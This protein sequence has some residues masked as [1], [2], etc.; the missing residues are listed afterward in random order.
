MSTLREW[1][2]TCAFICRD[3]PDVVNLHNMSMVAVIP[4]LWALRRIGFIKRLVWDQRELPD[5]LLDAGPVGR[6]TLKVLMLMCDQVASANAERRKFIGEHLGTKVR[7]RI[8]VIN[9]Y[10]DRAFAECPRMALPGPIVDWLRG[11][12]YLLAQSA[13]T[14]GRYFEEIAR[15]AI[16]L[17]RVPVVAVG[18]L[19]AALAM[20]LAALLEAPEAREWVWVQHEVIPDELPGFIDSSVAAIVLYDTRIEN[21]RLCAP[22][23]LFQ[24]LS[25]GVPVIGGSNPPIASVLNE[26]GS[27]LVLES[28]GRDVQDLRAGISLMLEDA[29]TFRRNAEA[30]RQRYLWESQSDTIA[31][32]LVGDRRADWVNQ[33]S[34]A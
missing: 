4:F 19:D 8:T 21:N 17:K 10:P 33:S 29:P 34:R 20:E 1:L 3:R 5:E 30:F 16:S 27:G 32:F 15:A 7:S 14:R 18:R 31:E 24:P 6:W 28:D 13:G 22:N 11:R 9:N 25:R 23:R 12:Q 26:T 2:T